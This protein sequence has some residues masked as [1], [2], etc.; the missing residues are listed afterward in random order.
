M[1][2]DGRMV[3]RE[4]GEQVKA[5]AERRRD[6]NFDSCRILWRRQAQPT[7]L[8]SGGTGTPTRIIIPPFRRASAS[9][10]VLRELGQ[11]DFGVHDQHLTSPSCDNGAQTLSSADQRQTSL[12]FTT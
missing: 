9:G 8:R 4:L 2:I 10:L 7:C 1:M 11:R 3:V 6:G 12:Y 5:K